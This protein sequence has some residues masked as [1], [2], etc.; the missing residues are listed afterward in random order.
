VGDGS[1]CCVVKP[2][3]QC[4]STYGWS[5][6]WGVAIAFAFQNILEDLFSSF[7]IVFDKPFKIGDFIIVGDKLG[8]V[9]KI[10]IKT[11]RIKSLQGEE[12]VISNKELTSAQVR[13]F[14]KMETRRI[15]FSFGVTYQTPTEKLKGIPK[16]VESIIEETDNVRFD[17]AH[18]NEFGDSALLF[19]VV[20]YVEGNDYNM[21]MD[22]QQ[23]INLKIKES[24][25]KDGI[26]MAYPTQTIFLQK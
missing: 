8:V 16:T 23:Q 13:N 3:C 4:D 11:T 2:W 19:E 22:A 7:A 24:F 15:S 1:A 21:Y 6:Y 25:E 5:W 10:G 20:Y 17:R 9:E 26:E 18:F 12:I 14:K